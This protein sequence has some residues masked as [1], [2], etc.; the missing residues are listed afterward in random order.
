MYCVT[1]GSL[2]ASLQAYE[3]V[4]SFLNYPHYNTYISD[5]TFLWWGN[6]VAQ[7][8]EA[9]S[10]KQEGRGFDSRECHWNFLLTQSCRLHCGPGVDWASDR[11]EYQEYFPGDKGGRCVWLTTLPPSCVDCL[12][13]WEPQPPGTL[14]A[15][16]GLLRDHFSFLWLWCS[17]WKLLY[18]HCN[19]ISLIIFCLLLR[20]I[21]TDHQIMHAAQTGKQP[22]S[23]PSLPLWFD[24]SSPC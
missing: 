22:F 15:C 1:V 18:Y 12:E 6:V 21:H 10:Y 20:L 19:C 14:R 4:A 17:D 23:C 3:S 9:L 2:A 5:S 24:E 7:L 16:P 8:V 13:I 11:N